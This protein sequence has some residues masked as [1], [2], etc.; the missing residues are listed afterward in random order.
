MSQLPDDVC[1][2]LE[3]FGR[4][5]RS[6]YGAA[7]LLVLVPALE[8][9]AAPA[10][11]SAAAVAAAEFFVLYQVGKAV[12]D[13]YTLHQWL[14]AE[15]DVWSP[16][17]AAWKQLTQN[18]STMLGRKGL[19]IG[20]G[21]TWMFSPQ[22]QW[23]RYVQ[24]VVESAAKAAPVGAHAGQRAAASKA[25]A[26]ALQS[27]LKMK[28][29]PGAMFYR[30]DASGG[31][32]MMTEALLL[33]MEFSRRVVAE[34][35]SWEVH[36]T[37]ANNAL[38]QEISGCLATIKRSWPARIT[39]SFGKA[40]WVF[41][42]TLLTLR[43]TAGGLTYAVVLAAIARTIDKEVMGPD[44]EW[45]VHHAW[46]FLWG[47]MA[48]HEIVDPRQGQAPAPAQ[49][50]TP[51]RS[52]PRTSAPDAAPAMTPDS[53][54][55]WNSSSPTALVDEVSGARFGPG[56][57]PP[58][59]YQ[60]V[61]LGE[62]GDEEQVSLGRVT[63][64]PGQHYRLDYFAASDQHP[65][66]KLRW[67]AGAA[68]GRLHRSP[69]QLGRSFRPEGASRGVRAG[70][71]QL[72]RSAASEASGRDARS[73]HGSRRAAEPSGRS[74]R[75]RREEWDRGRRGEEERGERQ[76]RPRWSD[77]RS[78][79]G[80]SGGVTSLREAVRSMDRY[81]SDAPFADGVDKGE[82]FV[83][84]RAAKGRFREA[85]REVPSTWRGW[86]VELFHHS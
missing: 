84:V 27:V 4:A 7:P 54:S 72:A 6:R 17:S 71:H 22:G 83:A 50:V 61:W 2:A 20:R 58:G 43:R 63:V 24:L 36:V 59:A 32:A 25:A 39:S 77:D 80:G 52:T 44:D 47:L 66:G 42:S 23:M 34:D 45:G 86:P 14:S 18:T 5:G 26:E 79:P 15:A 28:A 76:D 62:S 55:S 1:A 56:A 11:A 8:S 9:A 31:M 37:S 53:P 40:M 75:G 64:R 3:V 78:S 67:S 29:G 16:D 57:L 46:D 70:T 41:A 21:C 81:L 12:W 49:R 68:F 13:E 74:D 30:V 48:D 33:I 19:R 51:D 35:P 85:Q 69:H 38:S 60:V 10:A 65:G 73:G 82:G